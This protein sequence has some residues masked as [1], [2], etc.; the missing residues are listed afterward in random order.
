MPANLSSLILLP[1]GAAVL[2]PLLYAIATLRG[3]K[4]R[5]LYPLLRLKE[6]NGNT[7]VLKVEKD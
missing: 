6:R 2:A 5:C 1:V 7:F 4:H 3:M